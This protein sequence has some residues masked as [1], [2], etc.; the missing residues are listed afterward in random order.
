MK[1]IALLLLGFIFISFSTVQVENA[2]LTAVARK[3]VRCKLDLV[4]VQE[5]RWHLG[6]MAREGDYIF[7][8]RKGNKNGQLGTGFFCTPQNSVS[9]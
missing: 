2:S 7:F 1:Q 9:S 8:Y 5:V 3:L 4:G 6:G